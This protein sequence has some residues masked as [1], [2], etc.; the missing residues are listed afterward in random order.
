MNIQEIYD[1]VARH[2]LTQRAPSLSEEAEGCAY[3]GDNGLMCAVGC[4]ISDNHY[5]KDLEGHT[6]ESIEV[7]ESLLDSGID[8][9]DL[10]ISHLLKRFQDIH[11][12]TETIDWKFYINA[13]A[14][15]FNLTPLKD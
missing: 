12:K 3:R 15:D 8:M 13:L 7:I 14:D 6:V 4:L 10:N 11:D 2:L 5:S 9:K 1:K